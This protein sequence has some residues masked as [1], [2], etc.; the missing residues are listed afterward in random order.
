MALNCFEL[1]IQCYCL[2]TEFQ[3]IVKM[4]DTTFHDSRFFTKIWIN[5]YDQSEK[6]YNVNKEIRIKTPMLRS[7]LCNFSDAYIVI[8]GVIVITN[9]DDAKRRCKCL[10]RLFMTQDS[11]LKY[12]LTFMI[13]Q[14]KITMLTKKL[15]LRYQC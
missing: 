1:K 15:E 14:K 12:G 2:K 10:T 3:K 5:V 11:L 6:N 13:N 4:S 8:K 7:D 9:P